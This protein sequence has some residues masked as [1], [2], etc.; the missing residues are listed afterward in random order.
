M[1]LVRQFDAPVLAG[2][3]AASA[4]FAGQF[5]PDR[6]S[7]W[8]AHL[9]DSARCV[10]LATIDGGA[11]EADFPVRQILADA[12]LHG[13]AGIVLAHN[14]PSGDPTPSES[15]RRAMRRLASA[16]QAIDLEIL[17]HLIFAGNEVRSFRRMGLL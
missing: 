12:L 5:R 9:D 14:H 11:G 2:T 4:F 16:A 1:N 6:E 8:I 10:H 17:D 15:D 7:L 3:A 13:A